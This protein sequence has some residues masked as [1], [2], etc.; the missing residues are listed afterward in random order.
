MVV[1]GGLSLGEAGLPVAH[2][3]APALS[4]PGGN[5]EANRIFLKST[6]TEMRPQ[7]W[8]IPVGIDV[9]KVQSASKL[10]PQRLAEVST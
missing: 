2:R 4:R 5:F 1:L 9:I 3:Q 7:T 8:R 6:P 10:P